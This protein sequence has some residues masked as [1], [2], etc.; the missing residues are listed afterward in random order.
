[1]AGYNHR[2]TLVKFYDDDQGY[3]YPKF[4][5]NYHLRIA[6]AKRYEGSI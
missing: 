5:S 6:K 4:L 3:G 2:N 1:M